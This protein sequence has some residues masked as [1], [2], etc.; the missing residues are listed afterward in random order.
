[1]HAT[2]LLVAGALL[3]FDGTAASGVC[4]EKILTECFSAFDDLS[5]VTDM[6]RCL[7]AENCVAAGIDTARMCDC[8]LQ[9]GLPLNGRALS[10]YDC[11]PSP[12]A[13][14]ILHDWRQCV[15]LSRREPD[16]HEL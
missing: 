2:H 3:A 8:Y 10:E 1:M 14:T 7:E 6:K 5:C 11:H 4:D 16:M 9:V 12:M 13:N 15:E